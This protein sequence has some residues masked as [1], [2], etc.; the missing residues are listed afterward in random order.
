MAHSAAYNRA[1]AAL[2]TL[3]AIMQLEDAALAARIAAAKAIL[4]RAW[5]RPG[6][7][8]KTAPGSS[9]ESLSDAELEEM[10]R[11]QDSVTSAAT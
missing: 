2:E 4:D 5:G 6:P 9:L 7:E 11:K 3:A 8:E 1:A 10:I